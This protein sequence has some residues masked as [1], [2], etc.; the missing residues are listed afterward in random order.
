MG[1]SQVKF[2]PAVVDEARTPREAIALLRRL[3]HLEGHL[4]KA[5]H[6]SGGS[7]GNSMIATAQ[8][9]A[10]TFMSCKVANDADGDI[11]IADL[12]AAG[13]LEPG[14]RVAWLSNALVV[15]QPEPL[16]DG[17]E[18]ELVLTTL[19]REALPVIRYRTGELTAIL[20]DQDPGRGSGLFAPF[21]GVP[22][23]TSVLIP[24]LLQRTGARAFLVAC[25]RLPAG[26]GFALHFVPA[27]DALHDPD[28]ERATAAMNADIERLVRR[29]P[30]QYLSTT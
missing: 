5:S 7:A 4:V 23:N 17:Q 14:S 15:V 3:V 11:Y 25:V 19:S 9:G 2:N 21:F 24:R 26:R 18:G 8:F 30:E 22:A 12:E 28:V 29:F 16:P 20:P 6:A 27:A 1:C 13:L 10:P